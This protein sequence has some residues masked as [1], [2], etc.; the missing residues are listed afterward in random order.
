MP[1]AKKTTTA[2]KPATKKPATKKAPAKKPVEKKVEAAPEPVA[3]TTYKLTVVCTAGPVD[4]VFSDM[5]DY[6]RA[7]HQLEIALGSNYKGS[8][9]SVKADSGAY[10][11]ADA[12]LCYILA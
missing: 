2:K 8:A 3:P 1:T 12:H 5:G 4:L 10:M 9:V 11:F 6:S 7:L